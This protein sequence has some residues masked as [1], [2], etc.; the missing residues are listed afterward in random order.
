MCHS[1]GDGDDW[2]CG[3]SLKYLRDFIASLFVILG[4]FTGAL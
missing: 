3:R 4:F 1:N 2:D